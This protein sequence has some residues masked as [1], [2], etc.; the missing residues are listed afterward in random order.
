MLRSLDGTRR[1]IVVAGSAG[2]RDRA[3]RPLQGDVCARLADISIFT[4][5]DPRYEDARAIIDEIAEG[6]RAAGGRDGETLFTIE[7][8]TEAIEHAV[9][10]AETGDTVLL[11]GKGHERSIIINGQKTPWDE[12]DVARSAIRKRTGREHPR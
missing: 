9:A 12:A 8:R 5:E 11:A 4:N 3:K 7:D 2:E 6:A 10:L 1:I